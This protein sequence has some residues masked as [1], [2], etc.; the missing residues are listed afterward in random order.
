MWLYRYGQMPTIQKPLVV[1]FQN[2]FG[3]Q[4]C[5]NTAVREKDFLVYI[6]ANFSCTGGFGKYVLK[7]KFF[8]CT[9]TKCCLPF[10]GV[11]PSSSPPRVPLGTGRC[12]NAR[13]RET[14]H[15]F[16]EAGEICANTKSFASDSSALGI[17][18]EG[19][20]VQNLSKIPARKYS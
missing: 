7:L 20:L 18:T 3:F 1:Y 10:P 6:Y 5:Q 8:E 12:C 15:R 13:K 4:F 17:A 16:G 19:R 9:A 11:N 2:T 14:L